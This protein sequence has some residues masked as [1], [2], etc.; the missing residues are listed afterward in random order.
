MIERVQDLGN[1]NQVCQPFIVMDATIAIPFILYYET[2]LKTRVVSCYYT[3]HTKIDM[4]SPIFLFAS[5]QLHSV[6]SMPPRNCSKTS[7]E[8][9]LLKT[10][11]ADVTALDVVI[12][13]LLDEVTVASDFTAICIW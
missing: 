10:I 4:C 6:Q 5:L 1:L 2:C 8:I 11:V 7:L 9:N 13:S 3:C 12:A